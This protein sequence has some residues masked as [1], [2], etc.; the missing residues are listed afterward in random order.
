MTEQPSKIS[1][2][3][4]I[5]GLTVIVA[6]SGWL[7]T[8]RLRTAAKEQEFDDNGK[9]IVEIKNKLD[10]LP[11]N[12]VSRQELTELKEEIR[13]EHAET[14]FT[15]NH[16]SDRI[17]HLAMIQSSTRGKPMFFDRAPEETTA[18]KAKDQ[19]ISF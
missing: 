5:F 7:F 13:R 12:F 1:R 9:T 17:D 11:Q 16:L 3:V 19:Q 18:A 8:D 10:T 4:L 2:E 15:I 6:L 14:I